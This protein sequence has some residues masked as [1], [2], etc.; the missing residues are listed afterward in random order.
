MG[1]PVEQTQGILA[2]LKRLLRTLLSIAQ[3]R[4]ELLL[5][6]VQEERTRLIEAFLL[7]ISIVALGAM[8]LVMVTFTVVAIF[9]ENHRMAVL[10]GLSLFYLVVT[11]V[12][13]W[14]L[15][16]RLKNWPAFPATLAEL[17]KDKAW[18]DEHS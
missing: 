10:V 5:V 4:L 6:E 18:L 12:A 1:E 3:N 17:K 16:H 2:S 15:R 8:T 11:L 9:W 13:Y 7:A 14:R